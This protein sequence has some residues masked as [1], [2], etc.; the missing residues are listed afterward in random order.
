M[1]LRTHNPKS[2]IGLDIGNSSIKAVSLSHST[3]TT[4]L[5]GYGSIDT[6]TQLFVG[7][8]VLDATVLAQ[9]IDSLFTHPAYGSLSSDAV[10]VVL[11]AQLVHSRIVRLPKNNVKEQKKQLSRLLESSTSNS[12]DEIS[13]FSRKFHEEIGEDN[14]IHEL[15]SLTSIPKYTHS[16]IIDSLSGIG[17]RKHTV[18]SSVDGLSFSLQDRDSIGPVVVIDLGY[19]QS[20][21]YVFDS[22]AQLQS[23]YPRGSHD[24]INIICQDL[25]ISP[26]EAQL[27][28][29]KTGIVK[30]NLGDKVRG[31]IKPILDFYCREILSSVAMYN[32]IY[33]DT[34]SAICSIVLSG[35]VASSPGFAD[36]FANK[37]GLS[38]QVVNPW[39][40]ISIYPLKPMPKHL[41]PAYADAIGLAMT[42]DHLEI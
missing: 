19:T 4:Q 15:F 37:T 17:L 23:V 16:I 28:L 11:P 36:Y 13:V 27:V 25:H 12:T 14:I 39:R 33:S 5:L 31:V 3:D 29:K 7:N 40:N 22:Y 9:A 24:F 21:C 10:E 41:N 26:S 6:P 32:D 42:S 30:C 8:H 34:K 1:K 35:A 18:R 38:T 2:V 20:R